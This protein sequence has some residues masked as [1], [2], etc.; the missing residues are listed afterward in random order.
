MSEI[1]T[2]ANSQ[3]L[4]AEEIVYGVTPAADKFFKLPFKSINLD[5]QQSLIENDD[6]GMGR[7]NF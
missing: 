4:I 1:A 7:E 6:L 5:G 3:V 2:G